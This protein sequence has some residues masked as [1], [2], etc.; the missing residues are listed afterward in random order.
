M[1][2]SPTDKS[3]RQRILIVEDNEA[4]R[5]MLHETMSSDRFEVLVAA[6]GAEALE[7]AACYEL[8]AVLTDL[9]IPGMSGLDL[10]R[11]LRRQNDSFARNVPIWIMTGS[12]EAGI[13]KQVID[14]GACGLLRKPFSVPDVCVRLQQMLQLGRVRA[15]TTV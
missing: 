4:L 13:A 10:C 7:L 9:E 8:D 14:A 11:A 1:N 12:H 2:L 3:I 6:T 5:E 15:A